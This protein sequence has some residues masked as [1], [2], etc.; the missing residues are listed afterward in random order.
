MNTNV[1][2]KVVE[3]V[4]RISGQD[5]SSLNMSGDI[6]SQVR[7]DSMQFVE[8]FSALELEFGI[9]LPLSMMNVRN[10]GEF[11]RAFDA[12]MKKYGVH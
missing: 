9:D 8:L 10:A 5:C 11:F 2:T 12:E 1:E 6:R 3:I 4:S 7:L